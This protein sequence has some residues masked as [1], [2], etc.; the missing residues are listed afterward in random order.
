ISDGGSD[1]YDGGNYLNTN[2]GTSIP[3]TNGVVTANANFGAGGSYF[4][5]KVD[6]MFVMVADV[7]GLSSF[8]TSG[9][10]GAD[11][12]GTETGFT[13]TVTSGCQNYDVFV[14]RVCGAGDPSIN[15]LYIVPAGSGA[16]QALPGNTNDDL[17]TLNGLAGVTRLYYL[18]VGGN[19]GYCYSLAEFQ[20]MATTFL[21]QVNAS[22]IG[23]PLATVTQIAGLPSGSAFPVGTNVVTFEATSGGLSNTCSFNVNITNPFVAMTCPADI[24]RTECNPVATFT[25]PTVPE[26][27]FIPCENNTLSN[28]LTN[29]NANGVAITGAIPNP[30]SFTLDDG[31]TGTHIIDGG[32]DM[33]DG[34]NY[35]NTNLGTSIPYT[36]G[37]VTANANFG[38]GGSYF[39]QKINNMFI[40]VA[41]INNLNNFYTTGN[42][43]ADGGGTEAGFTFTITVGCTTYDVF[44]KQVCN[45]FDPSINHLYIVPAGSGASQ[46]LPGNTNDDSHILNGLNTATRLYYLL[47]AGNNGY[48]YTLAEFQAMATNF[49]TQVNASVS[50]GAPNATVTQIAGLPSGSSF[51]V[52]TN[53][54]TYQATS[55]SGATT[56]CSFNVNVASAANLTW[57]GSV[58]SDW[59]NPNNW[60]P[61][62]LPT[63]ASNVTIPN[64]S[65]NPSPDINATA[66]A[67]NVS[68]QIGGGLTLLGTN[69]LNV[70]GDFMNDGGVIPN[71]GTIAFVGTSMQNYTNNGSAILHN[72]VLNN[73]SHLTLLTDMVLENTGVFTF[74]AG[75]LIT[76]GT[77]KLDLYNNAVGA[78]TGYGANSFVQGR[79]QRSVFGTQSYDFPVGH[80]T[81]GYQLANVNYTVAPAGYSRLLSYFVDYASSSVPS[82]SLAECSATF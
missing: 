73:A 26:P 7:N 47:V 76:A 19:A 44:V 78:I 35:L 27:C 43:G 25:A 38:A 34:G 82:V 16:S 28:I 20:A 61:T 68:I 60:T 9:N 37:V 71:N 24:N 30:Y 59:F 41:D 57:N 14:K 75:R 70:C 10:N 12:N 69:T 62:C 42:N 48:C 18:L 6:N 8:Y 53:V 55:T 15:H 36:N 31:A 3:Y 54:V 22:A 50:F 66:N 49:L 46:T 63:C 4:T 51:P 17:H 11:G 67:R 77:F 58:S 2:I 23:Y 81:L 21:N 39:T 72:V 5:Q 52:G 79:L 65:P 74:Q 40:M 29:F 80:A 33:Y 1:M 64:V 32:N 13:F 45:T 56:S